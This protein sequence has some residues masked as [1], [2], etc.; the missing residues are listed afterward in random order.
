VRIHDLLCRLLFSCWWML[1]RISVGLDCEGVWDNVRVK[2]KRQCLHLATMFLNL[3]H[4]IV[5]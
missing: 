3:K 4:T 5:A 2:S 1:K